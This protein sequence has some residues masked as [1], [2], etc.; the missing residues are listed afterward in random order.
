MHQVHCGNSNYHYCKLS[1]SFLHL[2]T[3][4]LIETSARNNVVDDNYC[5]MCFLKS[6]DS[7]FTAKSNKPNDGSKKNDAIH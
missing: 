3:T 6:K 1:A 4:D 2:V 7:S 5:L